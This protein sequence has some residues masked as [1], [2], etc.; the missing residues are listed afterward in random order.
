MKKFLFNY[1]TAATFSNTIMA[2]SILL[3][4][5]PQT[6]AMQSI[7]EEH[8]LL[9]PRFRMTHGVDAFGNRIIYGS[10][11]EEHDSLAYVSTGI[12][13]IA[14]YVIPEKSPAA[15]YSIPS[16][17]TFPDE[18]IASLEM[19]FSEEEKPLNKAMAVCHLVNALLN[20]T[21][22]STYI[23]TPASEVLRQRCGVCQDYAHLMISI[24][25]LHGMTARYVAGFVKGTGATHA[26]VE[27][28]DG[29]AWHG[30][31]PT[32]DLLIE[33]GYIK[34]AHGRDACDCTVNRG[35]FMGLTEQRSE[36]FVSVIEL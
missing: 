11:R 29:Y 19:P 23:D 5:Q 1:Q 18:G 13:T 2:H 12:V 8:L 28:H 21:P 30:F 10:T 4:C 26:W 35:T 34:V 32:H 36:F 27:V 16:R 22:S 20:Y 7:D 25:R 17:L 24:C 6:N 14:E 15:Y 33:T 31:D 3:R 9:P